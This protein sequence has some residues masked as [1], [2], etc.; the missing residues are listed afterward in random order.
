MAVTLSVYQRINSSVNWHKYSFKNINFHPSKREIMNDDMP[1]NF[2]AWK[3]YENPVIFIIIMTDL[4]CVIKIL[5][6]I[7]I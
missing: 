4:Y 6:P 3:E 1:L 5:K 7:F 2:V